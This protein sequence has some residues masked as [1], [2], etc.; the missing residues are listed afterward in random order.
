MNRK[1]LTTNSGKCLQITLSPFETSVLIR[2]AAAANIPMIVA[3]MIDMGQ[4][5]DMQ[6]VGNT[7]RTFYNL[8]EK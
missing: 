2:L 5:T 8:L 7:I 1:I 4:Y 6:A 3:R